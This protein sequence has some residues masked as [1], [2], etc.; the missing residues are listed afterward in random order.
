[1]ETAV[2]AA[3]AAWPPEAPGVVAVS[4]GPDSVALVRA[5]LAVR[6]TGV[7]LAHVNHQ[8]RGDE[9]DAD[10]AFV[11]QLQEQGAAGSLL[12][13]ERLDPRQLAP[14]DNLESAA[15]RL[16]Y[17]WLTGV[18][19]DCGA[20]WVATGHT[21]DDQAETVLHR[22]LR[23]T[24]LRGLAGIPRR[25]ALGE[26]VTL[27]RPLLDV[28]RAE[29]LAYLEQLGQGFR[30]DRSNE[31]RRFTRNR[32]RHDLLPLLAREFNPAMVELL[33]RLGR[34][35]GEVQ[36]FV[37]E[38]ASRVLAEAELPRAG[39]V[40]VLDGRR[41]AGVAPLLVREALRLVWRREGWPEQDLDF[42]AWERAAA[43]VREEAVAVDMP[44]G[45][46]VRRV[47]Q[48]VQLVP[49]RRGR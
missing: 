20:A 16:R 2:R 32:L 49:A 36:E 14:G 26:G 34:Q 1:V 25:R 27:V 21:A 31:D 8:L 6:G 41:L 43:V 38:Q 48:V 35:A 40:V 42:D 45:I 12:R 9:S 17:E 4:G 5:V 22:L 30:I 24:G 33:E 3:L 46:Q 29:V 47:R 39:A 11:R 18:A 7:V 37:E 15:R 28:R 19:G 23:G 44:G 13:V 10:E